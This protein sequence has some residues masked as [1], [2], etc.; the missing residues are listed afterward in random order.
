MQV[1]KS[2]GK[3][4]MQ[5]KPGQRYNDPWMRS[6]TLAESLH[7]SRVTVYGPFDPKGVQPL[8]QKPDAT[9]MMTFRDEP[10]EGMTSRRFEGPA[11]SFVPT[12]PFR[13]RQASLR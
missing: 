1:P 7:Y 2:P 3:P 4:A 11:V 10:Y 6:I 13:Q 12:M 5:A 9:V 8:L